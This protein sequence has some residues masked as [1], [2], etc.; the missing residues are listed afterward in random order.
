[1]YIH[2]HFCIKIFRRNGR[3]VSFGRRKKIGFWGEKK[4]PR[5][6]FPAAPGIDTNDENKRK[7]FFRLLP[8]FRNVEREEDL[9]LEKAKSENYW[10]QQRCNKKS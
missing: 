2:M 8:D 6:G 4:I 5:T 7:I 3:T 9:S 10:M 1:M